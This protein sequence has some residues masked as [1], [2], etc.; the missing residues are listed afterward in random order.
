MSNVTIS[1]SFL[2]E[3]KHALDDALCLNNIPTA[4]DDFNPDL[5]CR[6]IIRLRVEL[7][8]MLTENSNENLA[9]CVNIHEELEK[10]IRLANGLHSH[11]N[12]LKLV[13]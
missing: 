13:A 6:R 9:T 11:L 12:K 3:I 2:Q 4:P 10:A 1:A 8:K 7:E 5:A